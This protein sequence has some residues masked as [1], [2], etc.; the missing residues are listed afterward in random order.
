LRASRSIPWNRV[1]VLRPVWCGV[2]ALLG[3]G[4]LAGCAEWATQPIEPG[5]IYANATPAIETP[6]TPTATQPATPTVTPTSATPLMA[7]G[8]A[9]DQVRELQARLKQLGVLTEDPDAAYGRIT[10]AAVAAFQEQNGLPAT[11]DVDQATWDALLSSTT[12][13]TP[14]QLRP[15]EPSAPPPTPVVL[16]PGCT[17]GGPALCVDKTASKVYFV[18]DGQLHMILDARFGRKGLP[19]REGE[20]EVE[21]KSRDHVSSIY[22]APMPYAMFFNGGQAVHY[23]PGFAAE[24]YNGASHGCVN[25]RD[26]QA[27]AAIFDSVSVGDPVIVYRS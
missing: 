4:A 5:S 9:G 21:S 25:T 3:A 2:V 22:D 6:T 10:S 26:K 18:V 1:R 24:G 8:S 20:F 16:H 7:I 23:S 11:G 27:T 17:Q 12:A 19:T 15:P 14:E 13:P